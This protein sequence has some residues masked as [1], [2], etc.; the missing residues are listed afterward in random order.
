MRLPRRRR[1]RR[2]RRGRHRPAATPRRTRSTTRSSSR[3]SPSA[4]S[5]RSTR[6]P[7]SSSTRRSCGR[8]SRRSSTR[9]RRRPTW[10]GQERL[11]KALGLIP[12]DASLRT[13]SLDLLSSGVA[14]FYRSDE[15]KLYVVSKN[16]G[17]PGPT[18]RFYFSHEYTHALQDQN[19]TIFKDF[20][21]VLDQSDELLA[22]QAI[23][24]GDAVLTMT[25]WAAANLTPADLGELLAS[26]ND[27]AAQAHRRAHPADPAGH[28]DVPVHD[29]LQLRRACQSTGGWPAVNAYFTKMPQSTEQILHPEKYTA[30]EAPIAV[31]M[32]ADL[33]T[34]LGSGLDRP[35]PGHVRGAPARDLAARG[36]ESPMPM[37]RRPPPAGAATAWPS[38]TART[39]RGPS[40]C[41]PSG[42]RRGCGRVRGGRQDGARQGGRRG[43]GPPRCRRHD[44]MGADRQ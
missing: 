9:T 8:C 27:P 37:P 12:A 15:S 17:Q 24:E 7:A 11:Y 6:S 25:Q 14:A 31:A 10:P 20:D 23:Y 21:K 19:S 18:E 36:A 29:R 40:R 44:P 35:A 3:S 28:P 43:A 5:S 34:R 26:G 2:G 38:W 41:T 33:A 42:T 16:G 1:P 4:A 30:G 22:R 32:P 13:L 39:T